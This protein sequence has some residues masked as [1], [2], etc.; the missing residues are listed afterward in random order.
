[1]KATRIAVGL[2][3]ALVTAGR[4]PGATTAGESNTWSAPTNGLQARL[5]LVEKPKLNGTRWLVPYLELRNVRDLAHPMEIQCVVRNSSDA[6]AQ[7]GLEMIARPKKG[8]LT[9][10]SHQGR[11]RCPHSIEQSQG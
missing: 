7:G 8:R 11:A 6:A 10:I 9:R 4:M 3:V 1:M 2:T 5:T